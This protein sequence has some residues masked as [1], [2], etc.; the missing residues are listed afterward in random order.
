MSRWIMVGR[1]PDYDK[2]IDER[3]ND[4]VSPVGEWGCSPLR[5]SSHGL[6]ISEEHAEILSRAPVLASRIDRAL[7]KIGSI[8]PGTPASHL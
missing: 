5:P 6:R 4:V 3:G 7:A 1:A 2:I 8:G